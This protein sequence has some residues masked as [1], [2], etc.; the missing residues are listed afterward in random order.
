LPFGRSDGEQTRLQNR[1]PADWLDPQPLR[2]GKKRDRS[3][4]EALPSIRLNSRSNL[5]WKGM[6]DEPKKWSRTWGWWAPLIVGIFYVVSV[7]P[8]VVALRWLVHYEVVAQGGSV[9]QSVGRFYAPVE[10][11]ASQNPQVYE[12]ISAIIRSLSP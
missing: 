6:S 1:L 10:W 3:V 8:L 12:T 4:Y 9:Y 2:D 5:A 7:V 11:L